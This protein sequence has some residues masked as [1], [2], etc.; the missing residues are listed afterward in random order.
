EMDGYE[1]CRHL[2]ERGVMDETPVIFLSGKTAEED[3]GR[4]FQMGAAT[5]IRKPFSNTTLKEIV[6]L[7]MS[8]LGKM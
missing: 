6:S 7:T 8:S 1:F 5:Y 2:Q 3:G 4:A